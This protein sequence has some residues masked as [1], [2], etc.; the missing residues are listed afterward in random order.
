[1]SA[2]PKCGHVVTAPNT[3]AVRIDDVWYTFDDIR[4]MRDVLRTRAQPV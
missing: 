4:A 2:C 1:M 3:S